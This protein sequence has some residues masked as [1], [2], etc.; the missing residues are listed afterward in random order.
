MFTILISKISTGGVWLLYVGLTALTVVYALSWGA[1]SWWVLDLVTHFR[2]QYVVGAAVLLLLSLAVRHF[3]AAGWAG[4]LLAANLLFLLPYLTPLAQAQ[5]PV[6]ETIKL[7][8]ANLYYHNQSPEKLLDLVEEQQPDLVLV[9]EMGSHR[10]F[11]EL[12]LAQ[13]Y[14]FVVGNGQSG[15]WIFSRWPLQAGEVDFSSPGRPNAVAELLW[16]GE[17]ITIV[18]VHTHAPF[19]GR[20]SHLRNLHLQ[21]LARLAQENEHI[22]IAGDFNVTPFS[23]HFQQFLTAGGVKDGRVGQGLNL[24]WPTIIPLFYI[25]IDQFV[26]SPTIQVQNFA[27]QPH[28]GSDHR[29]ILVEFALAPSN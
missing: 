27:T 10:S 20:A 23:P 5:A 2:G 25:P 26:S 16:Q 12:A 14:P 9:M 15:A 19:N 28:I 7:L 24:T 22:V 13:N 18:A 21:Q 8:S 4:V 1:T 17:L 3:W 29:P 11:L 6:G